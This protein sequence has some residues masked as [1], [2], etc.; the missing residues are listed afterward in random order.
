MRRWEMNGFGA[1][2]AALVEVPAPP[3][4]GP[5]EVRVGMRAWSLNYRDLLM[6]DGKYD[7]RLQAPW[8]PLSDG[9]GEVLEIGEG[10]SRVAV[11]DRVCPTFSPPWLSGP[12]TAEAVRQSRGGPVPG[13]L[14]E[15]IT[16]S[17]EA[18]VRV[19]AHLSWAQAA[20]L[21]CAGVTAHSALEF[22]EIGAGS[23]VVVLGSGGVSVWALQLAVARGAKVLATTSSER[24]AEHLR[25]LGAS[26]IVFYNEDERWGRTARKWAGPG[27]DLVVEV[28]GAGT[29]DQSLDAVRVGG[30]VAVI[31]VVAGAKQALSVL[32]ILMKQIR[33]QGVFVGSRAGFEAL[34]AEVAQH[35]IEPV[36][37][38]TFPFESWPDAMAHL[39]SGQ[40]VGKVCVSLS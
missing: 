14:A 5:G 9:A 8:V 16:T 35:A 12:P 22:G 2:H 15:Q 20:T 11:G 32:P 4:P 17:E 21:P 27:V 13:V 18:L 3:P 19:P 33:C 1:D 40:H 24:K 28:G 31:G 30:T 39:A 29:L 23:T 34:A 25:R 36:V 7:P 6:R 10:V 26:E 37:D 38:R